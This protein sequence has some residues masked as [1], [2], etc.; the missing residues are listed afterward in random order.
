MAEEQKSTEVHS[1]TP[2]ASKKQIK[3]KRKRGTR[4]EAN[5]LP[6]G[7]RP[8]PRVPL[9]KAIA[10]ARAI[11]EKNGGNPWPA[12]EVANALGVSPKGVGFVYSLLSS[13]KFGLTE[14][15]SGK[16]QVSLTALGRQLVYTAT[17]EEDLR[18]KHAT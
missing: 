18:F 7:K 11:K 2:A 5:R 9:E 16:G 8:S 12:P 10:V 17:S 14:R 13:K 6:S 4:S 3:R 1:T 15:T